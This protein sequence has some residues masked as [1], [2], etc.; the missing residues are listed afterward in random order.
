M[1]S[2]YLYNVRNISLFLLILNFITLTLYVFDQRMWGL[3]LF[4]VSSVLFCI[5]PYLQQKLIKN[6]TKMDV[7]FEDNKI[8]VRDDTYQGHHFFDNPDTIEKFVKKL[9]EEKV[10]C[11]LE[12]ESI[13]NIFSYLIRW[14]EGDLEERIPL[15]VANNQKQ[16]IQFVNCLNDLID[17]TDAFIRESLGAMKALSTKQ[18]YRIIVE[19]G[20]TGTFL[21]GAKRVNDGLLIFSKQNTKLMEKLQTDVKQIVSVVVSETNHVSKSCQETVFSCKKTLDKSS[22]AAIEAKNTHSGLQMIES[23]ASEL[24]D[25]GTE[26]VK[27][28]SDA[29]KLSQ[30]GELEIERTKT[31]VTELKTR[32]AAIHGIVEM[33]REVAQKT[34]LLSINAAIEAAKAGKEGHGFRIVADEVRSLAHTTMGSAEDIE[35][36]IKAIQEAIQ[37]TVTSVSKFTNTMGNINSVSATMFEK[38]D[39]QIHVLD[40]IS[41]KIKTFSNSMQHLITNVENVKD[42]STSARDSARIINDTFESLNQN[43]NILETSI[44]KTITDIQNQ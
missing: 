2:F 24:R 3:F 30:E 15:S 7:F 44:A 18:Y 34:N 31:T 38:I 6:F 8:L 1:N 11:N 16:M 40:G 5:L 10:V 21:L 36:Q 13:H 28:A 41:S 17:K 37:E 39:E 23:M 12:N 27:V 25:S 33:I 19:R 42:A 43:I 14:R 29:T 26:V 9:M 32:S 4:S 20:L 35:K 22:E